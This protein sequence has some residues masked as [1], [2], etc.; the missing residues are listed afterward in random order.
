MVVS[1]HSPEFYLAKM[2]WLWLA[3]IA[4]FTLGMVLWFGAGLGVAGFAAGVVPMIG[5]RRMW[6]RN[7]LGYSESMRQAG[8][9][10]FSV[11]DW[12]LIHESLVHVAAPNRPARSKTT[13]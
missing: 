13:S 7:M 6:D 12:L 8:R 1:L 3:M 5:A 10:P 2:G 4:F 9:Y 11:R